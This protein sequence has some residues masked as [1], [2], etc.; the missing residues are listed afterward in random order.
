MR[1]TGGGVKQRTS[2]S[3]RVFSDTD[4]VEELNTL[5]HLQASGWHASDSKAARI[6]EQLSGKVR[7]VWTWESTIPDRRPPEAHIEEILD[8]LGERPDAL[9]VI[10]REP[11]WRAEI[12]LG[13]FSLTTD[14]ED[15]LL[16]LAS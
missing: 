4:S 14:K 11:S 12:Y 15:L 7:S 9:A 16:A 6:N 8:M 10:A 3:F 13:Y 2:S 1:Y 5:L